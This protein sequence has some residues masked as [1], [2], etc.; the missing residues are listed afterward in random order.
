MLAIKSTHSSTFISINS[1]PTTNRFAEPFKE[2]LRL[3]FLLLS[4]PASLSHCILINSLSW[5][6]PSLV[7]LLHLSSPSSGSG[8]QQ[9]ER[10]VCKMKLKKS[11]LPRQSL[12][13]IECF[14]SQFDTNSRANAR[15]TL[16]SQLEALQKSQFSSFI[17]VVPF[18]WFHFN[19]SI[20]IHY[21]S[22][23]RRSH[24]ITMLHN[25]INSQSDSFSPEPSRGFAGRLAKKNRF[26][27]LCEF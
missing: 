27:I 2:F 15:S 18:R 6:F 9:R 17:V 8:R 5:R 19:F 22:E 20:Y 13:S 26:H 21:K 3:F 14:Q 11:Q 4:L 23:R 16:R 1:F 10:A 24:F 25:K 7:I 12:S